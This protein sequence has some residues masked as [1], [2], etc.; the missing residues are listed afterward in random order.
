[1]GPGGPWRRRA[2]PHDDK[3]G[4][5]PGLHLN[6]IHPCKAIATA[7]WEGVKFAENPE[8]VPAVQFMFF[9]SRSQ[10]RARPERDGEKDLTF[11]TG[12]DFRFDPFAEDYEFEVELPPTRVKVRIPLSLMKPSGDSSCGMLI[13]LGWQDSGRTL[14]RRVFVVTVRLDQIVVTIKQETITDPEWRVNVGV[15]GRWLYYAD[16]TTPGFRKDKA[17]TKEV[18]R[19]S[20]LTLNR[21]ITLFLAQDDTISVRVHGMEQDGLGDIMEL[22]PDRQHG[23]VPTEAVSALLKVLTTDFLS[24]RMLR[25][26]APVKLRVSSSQAP[27]TVQVPFI[28]RQVDWRRDLDTAADTSAAQKARTSIV[29]RAMF[30]RLAT[31]ALDANDPLGLIDPNIRFPQPNFG[32]TNDATDTKNPLTVDEVIKEVGLGRVKRCQLTAYETEVIGRMANLVYHPRSV[33][34]VIR[35]DVKVDAQP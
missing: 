13:S 16:G 7:R 35:Y 8:A 12:G 19:N 3:T 5:D 1:M 32:R 15:N 29:A 33:D 2:I 25:G 4:S 14:A 22:P 24:D 28:G 21:T 27:T 31:V 17:K 30:L 10:A 20:R 23:N 26:P 18:G 34:Y 9:A 11:N 6:Q